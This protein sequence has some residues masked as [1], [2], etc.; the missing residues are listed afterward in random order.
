M[1]VKIHELAPGHVPAMWTVRAG[2]V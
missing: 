1:V 2:L